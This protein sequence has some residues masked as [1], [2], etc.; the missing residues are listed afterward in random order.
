MA[1]QPQIPEMV[2]RV[3]NGSVIEAGHWLISR[4]RGNRCERIGE[5]Q[6]RRTKLAAEKRAEFNRRLELD[7]RR[8]LD[9]DLVGD[10]FEKRHGQRRQRVAFAV[11]DWE[12]DVG[13]AREGL[14][15]DE[16]ITGC[17]HGFDAP[18]H[19]LE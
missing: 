17:R 14:A 9:L 7:R 11:E 18:L 2:M 13:Y 1:I 4:E 12:T 5:R 15:R 3:D 6:A 8:P 10:R 16:F 19:T